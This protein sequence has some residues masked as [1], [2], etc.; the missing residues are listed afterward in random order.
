[1]THP[2]EDWRELAEQATYEMDPKKLIEIVTKLNLVLSEREE[3]SNPRGET[4]KGLAL[5]R[6][7]VS[8]RG[9]VA[10]YPFTIADAG[11]TPARSH[12]KAA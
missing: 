2:S 8:I 7:D 1:M 12:P 10:F 5:R 6:P 3:K 11:S 9:A 4:I